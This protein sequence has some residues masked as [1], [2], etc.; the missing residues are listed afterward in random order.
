M[1]ATALGGE[2]LGS[3]GQA[4]GGHGY[5][6][7]GMTR[8]ASGMALAGMGGFPMSRNAS[9]RSEAGAAAGNSTADFGARARRVG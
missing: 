8:Q 2:G 3:L 4:N 6:S 5:G 7:I 1:A 9:A